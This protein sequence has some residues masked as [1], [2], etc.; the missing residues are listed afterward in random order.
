MRSKFYC[1]F[2]VCLVT[3]S[4]IV[5][6]PGQRISKKYAPLVAKALKLSGNNRGELE[7]AIKLAP[8]SQEEGVAFLISYMPLRDL[9]TLKASFIL[10]NTA[11]AYKARHTFPWAKTI[12]NE[13]FLNEVLPYVS[14]NE[15]RENWRAEYF[16]TFSDRVK[17]CTTLEQAIDS[18]NK[19]INKVVNVEYNTNREKPDQSPAESMR[20]HMASCTG[21][22]IILADAFRAVGIPAR[23]AGTPLWTNMKGNHNWVEVWMNG[24]WYFTE[25]YMD[26]LNSSWFVED[27][28]KADPQK[29]IHWIYA[30]SYKPTGVYFPLVW[31]DS[32]RYVHAVNVTDRYI[33][34][35]QAKLSDQK[36]AAD[37]TLISIVLQKEEACSPTSNNRFATRIG[38]WLNGKEVDFGYSPAPTDD[39]NRFLKLKLKKN[40][41]YHFIFNDEKE[42]KQDKTVTTGNDSEKQIT[43]T[44]R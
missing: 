13:I 9:K 30:S 19:G 41:T 29:K 22:S 8:A 43:L 6:A 40:T 15:T 24:Q 32:I 36:L 44:L 26:K 14:L 12:P 1:L 38:V 31:D 39:M 7:K 33:R 35:Y 28:G 18:V 11:L 20:Q 4:S 16:K 3:V 21:L 10:G 34:I 42:I 25:F 17:G 23:V 37:E 2:F 5:A 27:A